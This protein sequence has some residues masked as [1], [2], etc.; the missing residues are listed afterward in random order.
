[1]FT[2][3]E[4]YLQKLESVNFITA[5]DNKMISDDGYIFWICTEFQSYKIEDFPVQC[6]LRVKKGNKHIFSY[7]AANNEDNA[8]ICTWFLSRYYKLESDNLRAEMNQQNVDRSNFEEKY[9]I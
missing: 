8:K 4:K 1:M 5:K 2:S 7:G 9:L 6:I 3:L